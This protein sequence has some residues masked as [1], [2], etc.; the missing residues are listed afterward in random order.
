[1]DL[2]EEHSWLTQATKINSPFSVHFLL[3]TSFTTIL[4]LF[5]DRLYALSKFLQGLL[6]WP[7]WQWIVSPTSLRTSCMWST[8][9]HICVPKFDG[10]KTP[11]AFLAKTLKNCTFL[12]SIFRSSLDLPGRKYIPNIRWI[13]SMQKVNTFVASAVS[14]TMQHSS[15]MAPKID[16]TMSTVFQSDSLSIPVTTV[17]VKISKRLGYC[18]GFLKFF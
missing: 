16:N 1:M 8:A 18:P 13:V 14:T 5:G 4:A 9:F 3:T 10:W 12:Q 6:E 2:S 11:R 15:D 17:L 7:A